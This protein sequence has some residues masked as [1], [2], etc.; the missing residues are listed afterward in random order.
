MT[1]GPAGPPPPIHAPRDPRPRG[2][3]ARYAAM[4]GARL[5]AT[6]TAAQLTDQELARRANM[7]LQAYQTLEAGAPGSLQLLT[8]DTVARLA[9]ILGTNP[10]HLLHEPD[11]T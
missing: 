1:A 3:K 5:R 8:A 2:E 4:L 9:E 11:P 10:A 7:D 6:R